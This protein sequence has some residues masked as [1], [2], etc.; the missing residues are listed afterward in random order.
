MCNGGF[1]LGVVSAGLGA[2]RAGS[3]RRWGASDRAMTSIGGAC[4]EA[5]EF[6]AVIGYKVAKQVS[7]R[8]FLSDRLGN[9]G[10]SIGRFE[11]LAQGD[12]VEGRPSLTTDH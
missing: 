6:R 1:G 2:A 11:S 10:R 12:L 8:K 9:G 5:R 7:N 3:T 4:P